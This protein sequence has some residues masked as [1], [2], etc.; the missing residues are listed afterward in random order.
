MTCS[1]TVSKLEETPINTT[2]TKPESFN[3]E[4]EFKIEDLKKAGT[5]IESKEGLRFTINKVVNNSGIF[6]FIWFN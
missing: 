2:E 4:R 3:I 6:G 1:K 5:V